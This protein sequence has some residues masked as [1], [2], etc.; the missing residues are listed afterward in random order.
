MQGDLRLFEIGAIFLPRDGGMPREEL[1]VGALIMGRRQPPHFTDPKSD[2]FDK[3]MT[4]DAWDAKALAQLVCAEAFGADAVSFV[5]GSGDELWELRQGE[6]RVGGVRALALDAPIWAK[7]AFGIELSLGVVDST[8]V[9]PPG[10]HAYRAAD[11]APVRA[12]AF[13]AIPSQPAS[14]MDLALLVPQ[15]VEAGSVERAIR[16]V[17]GDLLESILLFDEHT[18]GKIEPGSRSLAWR[19]TFRHPERTL[20]AKEMEGRRTNVL[21][22]LE[23]TL[24]VRPRST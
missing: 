14:T 18:G 6:K 12:K 23:K 2:E 24:N 8:A 19:L 1:H 21:R 11:S 7:P 9:A 17:A 20:S 5:A 13:R 16:D 10:Q 22:H 15:S 4:F 3:A